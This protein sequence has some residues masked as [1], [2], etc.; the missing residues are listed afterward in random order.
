MSLRSLR[1][2][3]SAFVDLSR[4]AFHVGAG[5]LDAARLLFGSG[6]E[7]LPTLTSRELEGCG[8]PGF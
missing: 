5:V 2:T 1:R 8:L 7:R 6:P 4:V 3:A